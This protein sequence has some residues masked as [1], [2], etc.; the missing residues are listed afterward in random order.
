MTSSH[1][2]LS[3]CSIE[4]LHYFSTCARILPE[5]FSVS[6][7][8]QVRNGLLLG[9]PTFPLLRRQG[10]RPYLPPR[11]LTD[12]PC[13]EACR[14][15]LCLEGF[16][17]LRGPPAGTCFLSMPSKHSNQTCRVLCFKKS[18]RNHLFLLKASRK[19]N[20]N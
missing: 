20:S 1:N 17:I 16:W 2:P 13:W 7:T 3:F 6:C 4:P 10:P 15:A 11:P 19:V 18:A 12:G 8:K 9:S 5:K 14:P